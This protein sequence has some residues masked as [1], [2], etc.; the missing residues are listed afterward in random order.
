[1]F[2]LSNRFQDSMRLPIEEQHEVNRIKSSVRANTDRMKAFLEH[3]INH[4]PTTFPQA[5]DNDVYACTPGAATETLGACAAG[6]APVHADARVPLLDESKATGPAAQ[7]L[8]ATRG[9]RGELPNA[10]RLWAH[11]VPAGKFLTAFRATLIYSGIGSTLPTSTKIAALLRTSRAN[12]APYSM[13]HGIAAAESAGVSG[14]SV[15]DI[16]NTES[17]SLATLDAKLAAILNWADHVA[18]NTAKHHDAIF[19]ALK[20][21]FNDTGIVE[22][23]ALCASANMFDRVENALRLP[24]EPPNQLARLYA[25]L[26]LAPAALKGYVQQILDTWP[27]NF[28]TPTD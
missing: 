20:P 8:S 5:S 9:L 19:E 26:A 21:H 12:R 13:A 3:M 15:L 14:G 7:Y 1:M 11:C 16:L 4:W 25:P 24:S 17:A 27:V 28:P 18:A 6:L 22:L 10:A 23:T 2:A